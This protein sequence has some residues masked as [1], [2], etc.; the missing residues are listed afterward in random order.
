MKDKDF[1][2]KLINWVR[3]QRQKK[4]RVSRTMIQKE[5]LTFSIDE[6][7]KASNG[8][9]EKFLL[10]H[11][12]V[13]RRPTTTCQKEPEEY[14]E[15]IVDYLLFVEQRRRTSFYNYIFAA[16][17]TAVYLDYSS[18]LTV[19]KKG[20][21]E[22]PVKTSGH[23]KLHVT[24]MLTARSDGFKCRPYILL[25]NKRPIKEIVNKFKNQLYL[26]WA[27][28]TFFNDELTSE[29]L[30]KI[31]G[32]SMFGKRLLAWDSYRCHISDATK[33]QLKKLQIDTA[34]I[35]GGCTKF[36]QAPDVYWNAPFKAKVRQFYEN[37]MLHGEKSYTKSGNMRAPSM[38]VYLKWIVDAWDELPKN[39]II[40]SFK[41]CG[42]TNALDGSEDYK[43]HCFRSDGQIPTGQELLQ[44][45]RAKA[46]ITTGELTQQL[47]VD[48][49]G[50]DEDG[51]NSDDSID[52][53]CD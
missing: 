14:G 38:E 44:Q 42:L 24:V 1:D 16:D 11:N 43:I 40:K 49:E 5:A 46:D 4:L 12:L 45:A 36:I 30:Q 32:S 23:D 18:S 25:K 27:G 22:V 50:V 52:F 31:I 10:R 6:N 13:S 7:F 20:V 35:P 33:K 29:Y 48:E 41:G 15:K 51:Y 26:C 19:E 28:R 17:E 8:W 39:L 37:W 53:Q 9:L 34:V 3:Q 47:Y 21:Q 2:E